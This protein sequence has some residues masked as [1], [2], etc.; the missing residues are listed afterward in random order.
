MISNNKVMVIAEACDN[1]FGKISNAIKMVDEAV[2]AKAD[3]IKFQHHLPDEEMLP[4]VPKSSNFKLDLYKFLKKY[5]LKIED[6]YKIYKYCKKK[7]IKYLCTPFSWKAA[8]EL[9]NI[10]VKF[11]KIGSGEFTDTPFIERLLSLRKPVIFSTGMSDKKEIDKM[12][13]FINSR[14]KNLVSFMN[15]T[16]EYPPKIKDIN[17]NF[18]PEMIKRYKNFVIGHS[19]HTNTTVTSIGAVSLGAKIIEKHVYLDNLNFGPDRDVSISFSQLKKLKEDISILERAIGSNKKIYPKEKKIRS[20]AR[21]SIVSVSDINVGEKFSY[22][23][24]WSKRPGTGI[25]SYLI[26]NI[27]GKKSK[28]KIFKDSLIKYSD[29]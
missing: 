14:K 9:N 25:P 18:I 28:K 17:L 5:A 8:Q 7:N 24:I 20:W 22:K 26:K 27:I 3:V 23:N 12:Y 19:D 21:R 29:Y 10:N 4:K 6:H 11:F 13:K 2:K 1:H 15:C 16:S